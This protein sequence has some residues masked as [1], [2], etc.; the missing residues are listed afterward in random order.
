MLGVTLAGGIVR[1]VRLVQSGMYHWSQIS[2]LVGQMT[3]SAFVGGITW[4]VC[5]YLE[6]PI[7]L[8]GPV[9]G[10]AGYMGGTLIDFTERNAL[11]IMQSRADALAQPPQPPQPPAGSP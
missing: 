10:M 2:A 4:A 3:I 9:V 8:I 11:R 1:F 5:V 7:I 6:V